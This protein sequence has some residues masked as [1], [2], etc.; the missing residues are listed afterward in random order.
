MNLLLVGLGL[1]SSLLTIGTAI[2]LATARPYRSADSVATSYDE[3]RRA[4]ELTPPEV[5]AQFRGFLSY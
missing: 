5:T 3:V 4:T 1:L 2:Y